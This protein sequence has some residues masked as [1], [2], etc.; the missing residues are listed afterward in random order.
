MISQKTE[1]ITNG[2][3]LIVLWRFRRYFNSKYMILTRFYKRSLHLLITKH[4]D[5]VSLYN[6]AVSVTKHKVFFT[7]PVRA[8]RCLDIYTTSITLERRYM[9]VRTTLCAY[10]E[11]LVKV[12]KKFKAHF[13]HITSLN[14]SFP[15]HTVF[16]QYRHICCWFLNE[17]ERK[18]FFRTL[19]V[20]CSHNNQL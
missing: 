20:S 5:G 10:W 13:L 12:I 15:N 2:I 1:T 16:I 6:F 17:G 11:P 8:Q 19:K 14:V 4:L 7:N 18:H 9:N 3:F